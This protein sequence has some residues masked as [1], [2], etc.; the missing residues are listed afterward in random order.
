MFNQK[1]RKIRTEIQYN[2]RVHQNLVQLNKL[3]DNLMRYSRRLFS[4]KRFKLDYS[5]VDLRLIATTIQNKFVK[6]VKSSNM[7]YLTEKKYLKL[8][9]FLSYD[10]IVKDLP[11]RIDDNVFIDVGNQLIQQYAQSKQLLSILAPDLKIYLD[12]HFKHNYLA[13]TVKCWEEMT[14]ATV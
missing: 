8:I 1:L 5:S 3:S 2:R 10:R 14:N 11:D 13:F 9:K 12:L 7:D 6:A 4:D